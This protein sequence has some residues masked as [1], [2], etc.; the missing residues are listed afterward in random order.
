MLAEQ[1]CG[2]NRYPG[3][4]H[5]QGEAG[6]DHRSEQRVVYLHHHAPFAQI[7]VIGEVG[8]C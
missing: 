4:R 5:L 3:G 6:H 2:L 1:R 8:V 7:R